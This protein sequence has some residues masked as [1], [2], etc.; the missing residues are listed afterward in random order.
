[1]MSEFEKRFSSDD[2]SSLLVSNSQL[3]TIPISTRTRANSNANLLD[4]NGPTGRR[5]SE[6]RT[7]KRFHS[8][9]DI[10]DICNAPVR[11]HPPGFSVSISFYSFSTTFFYVILFPF[12]Y[13]QCSEA[14][15]HMIIFDT[16]DM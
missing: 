14:L 12:K 4:M 9:D 6:T 13:S 7:R 15:I 3:V 1:M 16:F 10:F 11:L 8:M 2:L 5:N